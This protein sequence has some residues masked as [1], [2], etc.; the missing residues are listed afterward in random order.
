MSGVL[1]INITESAK[2]LYTLLKH[3]KMAQG[4]ERVQALYL[5]KTGQVETVQHLV[6]V[7]GRGRI[8]VQRWLHQYRQSGLSGLL[9]Q[10][11]SPGRPK[12]IPDWA[13]EQL[14]QELQDPEG[15]ESYVEVRTWLRAVLGIE[16]LRC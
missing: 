6:V 1:K 13:V 11:L 16:T 15:F 12:A 4:K 2:E 9:R 5:L 10:K 14:R 3:Q 8:T 7:L